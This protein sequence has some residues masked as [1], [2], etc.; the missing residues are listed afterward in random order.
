MTKINLNLNDITAR[1]RPILQK[2]RH[3]VVFI[4]FIVV[5][6]MYTFLVFRINSLSSQEPTDDQVTEGLQT[7]RRPKIDQ[8]ALNKIQQLQ[9]NSEEVRSLFKQ[10]RDNPFQE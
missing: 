7:V 2:L 10:A 6:L 1:I 3:Y 8:N 5:A 4:F 9:D